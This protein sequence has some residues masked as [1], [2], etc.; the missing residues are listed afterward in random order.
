MTARDDLDRRLEAWFEADAVRREPEHL[1]GEVLARTARTRRRPAWRVPERWIP[2]ST[3]TTRTAE[4]PR[5]P[6]RLVGV[7]A[8]LVLGLAIG[9]AFVAGGQGRGLS[10]SESILG[11]WVTAGDGYIEFRD[12]GSYDVGYIRS[13]GGIEWGTWSIDEKVLSMVPAVD[14]VFCAGT[15]GAYEIA[16]VDDGNRLVTT[17]LDDEC[18]SRRED[19]GSELGLTRHRDAEP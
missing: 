17:L 2:M 16:L 10:L 12:D 14:S 13:T 19:F 18:R 5:V 11:T 6:W 3:I 15:G 8:L 4:A 1:L 7:A 9:T